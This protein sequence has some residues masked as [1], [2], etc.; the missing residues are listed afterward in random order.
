[1]FFKG[2]IPFVRLLIPFI[3]GIV[4]ALQ[5]GFEHFYNVI[6]GLLSITSLGIVILNIYYKRWHVFKKRWLPGLLI[7]IFLFLAGFIITIQSTQILNTDHFSKIK[8]QALVVNSISEPKLTG[9]ILR[10]EATV[11]Q[12]INFNTAFP[13]TGKLLIAL[14]TNTDKP[15]QINYGDVFLIDNKFNEIDPPFN[16]S[17][18]NFKAYLSNNQ[19]YHQTFINQDQLSLI[20]KNDGNVFLSFSKALRKTLVAKFQQ[21]IP[22]KEASS[23]AS[24]LILGYRA[25]LSKETVQAFSKTGTMHVLSVSGMHV[26]IV[27]LLLNFLLKPLS[28]NFNYLR[29]LILIFAIWFYSLITGFSPSVCRAATMLTFVIAG[30]AFNKNQNTYNLLAIS[31]FLLLL[32]N[33]FYLL[34]VGFQLS[35]LAVIGLVYLHPKIYHSFH[36]KN[37][38]VNSVWNYSALSIAAQLA[39]FPISI[40]YF[41]QFPVYFLLG[42]L[43]IA[44]PVALI[45]YVG[46][47]FLFIPFIWILNPLGIIINWMI[48][49]V[50]QILIYIEHLPFSS[51]NGLW[52]TSIQYI[53]IYFILASL[54]AFISLKN[55][56]AL[57]LIAPLV[58]VFCLSTSYK[59]FLDKNRH[60]LIFYS[61]RKNSAIGYF[62]EGKSIL[63]SDFQQADKTK[64]FSVEPSIDSRNANPAKLVNYNDPVQFS[65]FM[66]SAG[67]LQFGN[68]KLLRWTPEYNRLNFNR[69]LKVNA[70]LIS[71][72]P[73]INLQQIQKNIEFELLLIDATNYDYNITR[74]K[75]EAHDLEIR[76]HIL[77]K[78]PAVIIKL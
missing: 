38:F 47:L 24:T 36:V 12:V 9:D 40:Y 15:L 57:K 31:A 5:K 6:P 63:I 61:L 14:K 76:A 54:I 13:S 22:D 43:I 49:K 70:V 41:H 33:P 16:P 7:H 29:I 71:A 23:V 18:F 3:L 27:C 25:D 66:S 1:M 52:I 67:F 59:V 30:K 44:I 19:I 46:I 8:G 21:Y 34:D 72:N 32:L 45:M 64:L 39:T 69:K 10:F 55:R 77:K 74:W 4:F 17:E 48:L 73:K 26:G 11:L 65:G 53:L 68:Y 37:K 60:E 50:N 28:K 56:F 42:N 20:R 75:Q 62:Y 58:L 51:L 78:N 2:E 35:Y